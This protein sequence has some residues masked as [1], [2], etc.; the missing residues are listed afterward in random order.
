MSPAKLG[1]PSIVCVCGNRHQQFRRS[2]AATANPTVTQALCTGGAHSTNETPRPHEPG[3]R[4][5][6]RSSPSDL[7]HNVNDARRGSGSGMT[8]SGSSRPCDGTGSNDSGA[9]QSQRRK[10]SRISGV[11]APTARIHNFL[12]CGQSRTGQQPRVRRCCADPAVEPNLSKPATP[13]KS[14][15]ETITMSTFFASLRYA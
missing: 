8:W 15:P 7:V 13:P 5:H 4:D 6:Q 11:V 12:R 10:R 3:W 9:R 1:G 2:A 14:D